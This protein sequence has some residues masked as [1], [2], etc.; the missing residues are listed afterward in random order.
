MINCEDKIRYPVPPEILERISDY[1]ELLTKSISESAKEAIADL[2]PALLSWGKGKVSFVRNRRV[3]DD[4]GKY[5]KM[6]PN[7]DGFCDPGVTVLK[8]TK[9]D[10]TLRGIIF[11]L[12]CHAVTLGPDNIKLCGDYPG[13]TKEYLKEKHRGVVPLFVQGCGADAN[14]EPRS[15]VDQ[16]DWVQRQGKELADEVDR[17][18]A[19]ELTPLSGPII[20]AKEEITLPIRQRTR[21]QIEEEVKGKE[22][23]SHNPK[24]ILKMLE[25]GETPPD[26]H[27]APSAMWKFGDGLTLVAL[28]G[29]TVGE[30]IPLI[31]NKIPSEKLWFA[32]YCNEVFGYLPTARIIHEGGYEDRGLVYE[33]GQFAEEVEDVVLESVERLYNKLS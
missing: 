31:K 21:E 27:M 11:S 24:R 28:P 9:P 26:T 23:A 17:I 20:T 1:L 7:P 12:S 6:G 13:F 19:Q 4:D 22:A 10:G 33:V 3:F 18:I 2:E 32:G 8:I 25:R 16:M 15:T 5:L 30:Y 14:T 29:E